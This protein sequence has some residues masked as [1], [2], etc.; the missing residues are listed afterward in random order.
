MAAAKEAILL[1]DAMEAVIAAV[2]LDGGFD[3]ARDVVLRHW[4]GRIGAVQADARDAKTA[5]QEWAQARRAGAAHL[6][7]MGRDG[8]DHQPVFTVGWLASGEGR[9]RPL[10]NKTCGGTSCRKGAAGAIGE[11]E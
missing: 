3:A 6:Y 11:A 8:P 7:Q 5:L 4:S 10:W 9:N 1:G 2:Y